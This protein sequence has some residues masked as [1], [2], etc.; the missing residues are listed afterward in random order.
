[1]SSRS[2]RPTR[3]SNLRI[4]SWAMIWRTSSAT[5]KEVVDHVFGLAAQN[6][7]QLAD[8]AWA[9]PT[10][11]V[12]GGTAHHDMQPSTTS[13]AVAK[14][15]SSAPSSAAMTTSRPV[16]IWPSACTRTRPRRRFSTRVCWVSGQA[17]F[18]RGG[19]RA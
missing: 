14:P 18:P 13:G 3:S 4:P 8:L 2:E 17:D 6:L 7:A 5:K 19:R 12:S 10:G 1:M 9:T 16:F 15:N 11:Q